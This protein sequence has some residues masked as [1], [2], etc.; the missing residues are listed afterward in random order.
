MPNPPEARSIPLFIALA[1]TSL[2][3]CS[4]PFVVGD[5][6]TDATGTDTTTDAATSDTATSDPTTTDAAPAVCGDGQVAGDEACDDGDDDDPH[7]GCD[8][9]C[10]RTGV[11]EWTF[12][13]HRGPAS[14][15][16][17]VAVAIDSTG[18]ILVLGAHD[19]GATVFALDPGGA[20][21]WQRPFTDISYFSI[22]VDGADRIYLGGMR[23]TVRCLTQ[24][25]ADVWAVDDLENHVSEV[26]GLALADDALYGVGREVAV[27]GEGARL[28]LRRHDLTSGAVAWKTL[29]P[30]EFLDANG[31]AVA[32]SGPNIV[33]V[34]W[35][36]TMIMIDGDGPGGQ[37]VP[38]PLVTAFTTDGKLFS[39]E[40]GEEGRLWHD[41]APIGQGDL[42]LT[43]YGPETDMVVRRLGADR[44]E[45]WTHIDG[46]VPGVWGKGIAVG[47]G[48]AI[49]VAGLDFIKNDGQ[50][51]L[52]RGHSGDGDIVWTS[53]FTGAIDDR[54]DAAEDVAFG[55]GFIVAVGRESVSADDPFTTRLW[56]RR[57]ASE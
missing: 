45:K 13:H 31:E 6:P 54:V 49:V 5:N 3:A 17:A 41:V 12:E 38:Q 56:A 34:G 32:L 26:H 24:Q 1:L 29:T 9:T 57:F 21:L 28:V 33:A 53:V 16:A 10:N 39:I 18:K 19:D 52:V 47:P 4:L 35:G 55:P 27:D 43:G 20:E 42:V 50:D 48:E 22:A 36:A 46:D 25:G 51:A 30:P 8:A 2:P 23:G 37:I 40:W 14:Q 44:A 11:L 7:D 15:D